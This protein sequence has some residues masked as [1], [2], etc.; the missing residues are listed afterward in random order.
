MRIG[1]RISEPSLSQQVKRGDTIIEVMFA[2]AI[3]SL[4]AIITIT[5]MHLGLAASERSLELVTARNELN[6]QAEALRFIHSSYISELTLPTWGNLSPAEQ[7]DPNVKYQQFADLWETLIDNT[8]NPVCGEGETE[9]CYSIEYPVGH[10]EDV[11][12][13]EDNNAL[14]RNH[15]FVLN[16]RQILS[17][18][19][20]GEDTGAIIYARNNP[21]I[22]VQPTLNARILY[23]NSIT[24]GVGGSSDD[25][26]T[27]LRD[28]TRVLRAEGIWVVGVRG[29]VTNG[30]QPQYYDFY[31]ETCWYGSGNAA[32]SSLDAVIRLYNPRG[33]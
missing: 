3:F 9:D 22:F 12:Q 30:S 14:I 24:P 15:A 20:R 31:I 16:T 21:G 8:V 29:P 19:G 28:Y 26:L 27:S 1:P 10:C 4:I 17:P 6:A 11:Y 33:A 23:T 2:F 5:M 25:Q 18:E 32:P 13:P 7:N